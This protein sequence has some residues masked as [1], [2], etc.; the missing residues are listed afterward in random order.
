MQCTPF[1][2]LV[3]VNTETPWES[4]VELSNLGLINLIAVNRSAVDALWQFIGEV[5]PKNEELLA[6]RDIE[7]QQPGIT[8][9][10]HGVCCNSAAEM[11]IFIQVIVSK[12]SDVFPTA[13]SSGDRCFSDIFG[14]T[15]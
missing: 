12:R 1:S 4:T 15:S 5:A 9:V 10:Y 3:L 7:I 14:E 8:R 13:V 2:S 11:F 6:K